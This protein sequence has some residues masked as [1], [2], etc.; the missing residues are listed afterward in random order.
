MTEN[1]VTFAEEIGPNLNIVSTLSTMD[2]TSSAGPCQPLPSELKDCTFPNTIINSKGHVRSFHES[3]YYKKLGDGKFVNRTWIS[4][5]ISLNRY[6]CY[7]CK[8]FGLPRA[9]QNYLAIHGSN[10]YKNISRNITQHEVSPDHIQSEIARGLYMNHKRIDINLLES[11]NRQVAENREILKCVIE[12]LL[13]TARQKIALRGHNEKID[14]AYRGNFLEVIK[15]LSI[16]HA[17]LRSHLEQIN[18]QGTHNRVTFLY[19]VSQNVLLNIMSDM[20]RSKILQD[21]KRSGLF[22][23]I[24]DTTT[25]I[26]NVEQ[27]T[28]IIRFV[29]EEGKVQE[30]LVALAAAPDATGLGM[31]NV[32]CDI[33]EKY[34]INWKEELLGQAYDGANSMQGQYSGLRTR[35]QNENPR[36]VYIWC[37]AHLLNLVVVDTCDYCTDS[38]SF[39]GEIASIVEFLRTRKRTAVFLKYQEIKYPKQ[40]KRRL[41]RFSNTRWTSHDRVLLVIYEKFN[42]LVASLDEISTGKDFDRDSMS[43][44]K[45]FK[46]IITSF[47]FVLILIFMRNIF[48]I[49]TEVSN[50]LQSISIDYI[51]AIKLVDVAKHRLRVMRSEVGCINVINDA[52]IFANDN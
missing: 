33:T 41:Q 32:F 28:F 50:Y 24:I 7:T 42:A 39:Y 23:V 6:Y 34:Q 22:S 10:D 3:Y 48:A 9:K 51:A 46:N 27:Y 26:A 4:Y 8:L 25:D 37:S 17:P 36:A 19:N 12:A 21:V 14:S 29:S 30:R 52:K 49:T 40:R 35:I 13:F 5:S 2:N 18:S 47:K 1:A 31:F 11:K 20:V 44:A 45:S 16:Y 38:K 15:L 43:Y